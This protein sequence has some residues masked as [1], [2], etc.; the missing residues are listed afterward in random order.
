MRGAA[1]FGLIG[2]V[3]FL[4]AS[5]Q[6]VSAGFAFYGVSWSVFSHAV[7]RGSDVTFPRNSPIEI[8]FA[9]HADPSPVEAK[10]EQFPSK[11]PAFAQR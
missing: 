3:F 6:P 1:G 7:A 2:R 11:R 10:P 5:S 9:A 4:L 8:R